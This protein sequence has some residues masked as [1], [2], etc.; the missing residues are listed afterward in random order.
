MVYHWMM[1]RPQRHLDDRYCRCHA[2]GVAPGRLTNGCGRP[3]YDA[4]GTGKLQEGNGN[5]SSADG[6]GTRG[7]VRALL[8]VSTQMGQGTEAVEHVKGG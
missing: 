7:H 3:K 8:S 6:R 1:P 2:Q 5:H 4:D